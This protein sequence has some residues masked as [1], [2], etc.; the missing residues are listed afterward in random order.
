MK[1]DISDSALEKKM[2]NLLEDWP[3]EYM[4][5]VLNTYYS[6]RVQQ[7]VNDKKYWEIEKLEWLL[8]LFGLIDNI[9]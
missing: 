6:I 2:E 3:K 1:V 4:K 5:D 7:S 8:D 9:G